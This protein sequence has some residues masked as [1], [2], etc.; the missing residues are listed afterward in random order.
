MA[1]HQERT[2]HMK[3]KGLLVLTA[4]L[5]TGLVLGSCGGATTSSSENVETSSSS[6]S[7]P[8]TS[9]GSESSSEATSAYTATRV[10][11]SSK[12]PDKAVVGE[13]IDFGQYITVTAP[14]NGTF[15]LRVREGS[16]GAAVIDGHN[17]TITKAGSIGIQV[18]GA[19]DAN[20]R[21][22]TVTA[23]AAESKE[24]AVEVAGFDTN[25]A[26]SACA[27]IPEASL[28]CLVRNLVHN[29]VHYVP[30]GGSVTI[31][32]RQTGDRLSL[33]VADNGPGGKRA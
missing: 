16:T 10:T 5:G 27:A 8:S 25:E 32:F 12:T 21:L 14:E 23:L 33:C 11:I 7:Q 1:K 6:E 22:W 31:A 4:L 9:Q 15:G 28:F 24:I 26:Q 2:K 13:T 20:L 17:V 29:A 3:S 18:V 30:Q 19:N